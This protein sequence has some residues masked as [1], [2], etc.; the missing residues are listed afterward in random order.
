MQQFTATAYTTERNGAR[1]SR[2]AYVTLRLILG[3]VFVYAGA[4]KLVDPDAFAAVIAA[5]GLMPEALVPFAALGLPILEVIAGI[6]LVLD[7]RG[8]L[9]AVAL[10]T[11][12]FLGVLAYGMAL[13]LDADCGCYGPGD[14][15]GE[16]FHGLPGAF[17]RDLVMA[18]AIAWLYAWRFR[19]RPGLRRPL[20]LLARIAGAKQ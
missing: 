4:T 1:W 2:R 15:E 7:V 5:Y 18:A 10:M 20:G 11:V 16:A 14:P 9:G 3:A 19:H 12:L 13:G 8:S 17:M 6:G